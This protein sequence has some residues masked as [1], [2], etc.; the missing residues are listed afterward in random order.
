M[1]GVAVGAGVYVG[2][3]VGVIVGVLVGGCGVAVGGGWGVSVGGCVSGSAGLKATAVS[4]SAGSDPAGTTTRIGVGVK[5]GTGVR[6]GSPRPNTPQPVNSVT[7]AV[8][9]IDLHTAAYANLCAA[10]KTAHRATA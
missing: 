4:A 8:S 1:V 2:V 5:V 10:Q 7:A 6:V 3:I 9:A